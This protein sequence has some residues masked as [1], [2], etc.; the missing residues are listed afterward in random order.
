MVRFYARFDEGRFARAE[1]LRAHVE[2]LSWE[3]PS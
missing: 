2:G 3:E 1:L